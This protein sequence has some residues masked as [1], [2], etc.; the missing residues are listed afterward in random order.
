M[1]FP[2]YANP[3]VRGM[4]GF[5][6]TTFLSAAWSM[7]I[8]TIPVLA[9]YFSITAGGAAQ[10]VTAFAIA[11][12]GMERIGRKWCTVPSTGL[13]ALAFVLIPMTRSFTQLAVLVGFAAIAQGLALGSVA[14]STYDVVPA[15]V[16]GRL[17]AARRSLFTPRA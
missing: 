10:I 1:S 4:A 3:V 2:A 17:Q 15:H 14:T 12:F 16:R 8:P 11:G 7:I 13:P 6:T 9:Q 5:Y